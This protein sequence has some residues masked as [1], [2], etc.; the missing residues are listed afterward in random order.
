M[1]I[2]QV[3]CIVSFVRDV[4]LPM[5]KGLKMVEGIQ[6]GVLPAIFRLTTMLPIVV[7]TKLFVIDNR[8]QKH[9]RC[10]HFPH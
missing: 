9:I 6:R 3:S 4:M 2:C 5:Q 1:T 10:S 7:Q 8:M